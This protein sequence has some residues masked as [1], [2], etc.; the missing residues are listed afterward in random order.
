MCGGIRFYAKYS[1]LTWTLIWSNVSETWGGNFWYFSYTVWWKCE[2]IPVLEGTP[3]YSEQIHQSG[4]CH[5][6]MIDSGRVTPHSALVVTPERKKRLKPKVK[7]V[8]TSRFYAHS[9]SYLHKRKSLQT[10]IPLLVRKKEEEYNV[11][12]VKSNRQWYM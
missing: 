10:Q 2:T 7:V 11:T 8:L 1:K 12:F 9:S 6:A 5:G 4:N 3:S